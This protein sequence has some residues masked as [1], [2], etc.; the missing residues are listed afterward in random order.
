MKRMHV[1]CIILA[2]AGL[3]CAMMA[4]GTFTGLGTQD[5][6]VTGM[7]ADGSIV[8]GTRSNFG[9][10]FK[11]SNGVVENIGG[12]GF[13]AKISRDGKVIVS[14]ATDS[15]GI[16]SAAIWQGGT[17]WRTLGGIPNGKTIDGTV[18]SAYDVSGDG[19]VIVGL[20]WHSSGKS[21][22]FLWSAVSGMVDLGSLQNDSSRASAV[23]GNGSVVVGWDNNSMPSEYLPR[24]GAI[25]FESAERLVH[26]YGWIGE[27]GGVNFDGHYL[28]GRGCP[29]KPR[30]ASLYRADTAV[31][32]DLGAIP[33]GLSPTIRDQE[34]MSFANGVSDDGSV[35]IGASG[36]MPPLDAFIWLKGQAK[37][38][39]LSTYLAES[40]I[41]GF[42]KWTLLYVSAVSPNGKILCGVG[43][44]PASQVEGWIVTLQ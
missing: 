13:Q 22:A 41:M 18:S 39:K 30:H 17:N 14:D 27:V 29:A 23:S 8:V 19:S 5:T 10:V 38:M 36:W 43:V 33:R 40:G 35:V 3:P 26:P 11:W 32:R 9:P 20:A 28:V 15:Q 42:E 24:R 16:T 4:Q 25:W 2:G 12:V 34:D 1:L 37:I 21:R 7:S 31:C 44:N 6:Y